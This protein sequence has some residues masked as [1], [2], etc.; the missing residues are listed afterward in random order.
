MTKPWTMKETTIY[1]ASVASAA[2]SD[3]C[4]VAEDMGSE[5]SK[6]GYRGFRC[7]DELRTTEKI[8]IY[9][10]SMV[11]STQNYK[12]ISDVLMTTTTFSIWLGTWKP[13]WTCGNKENW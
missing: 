12:E 9:N 4:N 8:R 11:D 5:A 3:A 2:A 1:Q 6:L 7:W 13:E 10:I